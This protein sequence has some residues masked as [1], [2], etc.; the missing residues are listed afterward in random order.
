MSDSASSQ[1][2][3]PHCSPFHISR[4][5]IRR[6]SK[7][8]QTWGKFKKQWQIL[9]SK[10]MGSCLR[11]SHFRSLNLHLSMLSLGRGRGRKTF[12]CQS[13]IGKSRILPCIQPKSTMPCRSFL[14]QCGWLTKSIS[15][16]CAPSVLFLYCIDY[17]YF[18][19]PTLKWLIL[20]FDYSWFNLTPF[21]PPKAIYS[22]LSQKMYYV[23]SNTFSY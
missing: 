10:S 1:D 13:S 3:A 15:T 21:F 2:P 22:I 5:A 23:Q 9:N 14:Q 6:D 4:L 11:D 8:K 18:P 12:I 20:V 19:C 16:F 7:E 17:K